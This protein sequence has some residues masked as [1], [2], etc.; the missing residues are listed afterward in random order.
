[1]DKSVIEKEIREKTKAAEAYMQSVKEEIAIL[2]DKARVRAYWGEYG[3]GE[4]YY[5]V[6]TDVQ[7]E[8]IRWQTSDITDENGLLTE[9]IWIAS[10][11]MC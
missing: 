4:T 5:P 1:M 6:G 8:Y 10:S 11:D 9:G 7:A 3:S 2:A